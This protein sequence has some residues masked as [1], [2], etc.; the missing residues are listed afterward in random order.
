M[1]V[2]PTSSSSNWASFSKIIHCS[3]ITERIVIVSK[4]VIYFFFMYVFVPGFPQSDFFLV[5]D[6]G[7][8]S[9]MSGYLGIISYE[10]AARECDT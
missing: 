3:K 4:D 8:F 1:F 5:L 6:V 9:V 2:C 7:I 10:Y